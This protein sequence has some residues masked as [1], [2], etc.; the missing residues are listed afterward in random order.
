MRLTYDHIV[1]TYTEM[2]KFSSIHGEQKTVFELG[3]YI[4]VT[5]KVREYL[6]LDNTNRED[7]NCAIYAKAHSERPFVAHWASVYLR[8]CTVVKTGSLAPYHLY[9]N[10]RPEA[11]SGA[12]AVSG[13]SFIFFDQTQ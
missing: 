1:N 6:D 9:Y 13:N 12:M 5:E 4:T 8:P 3:D 2:Q 11:Y 10:V 7:D